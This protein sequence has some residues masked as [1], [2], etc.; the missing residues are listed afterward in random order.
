[1]H[2]LNALANIHNGVFLMHAHKKHPEEVRA[3]VT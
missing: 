3:K 1:M 2:I